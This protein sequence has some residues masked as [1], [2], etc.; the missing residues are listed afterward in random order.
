MACPRTP[1]RR[2][3]RIRLRASEVDL[4]GNLQNA[5]LVLRRQKV[6]MARVDR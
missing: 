3:L 2:A 1:G 5:R 6:V 4:L